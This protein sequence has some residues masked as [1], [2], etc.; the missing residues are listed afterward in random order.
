MNS[1][2]ILQH[3]TKRNE[4]FFQQKTIKTKLN[5]RAGIN[6]TISVFISKKNLDQ[7]ECGAMKIISCNDI[8]AMIFINDIFS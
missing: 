2:Q 3:K 1:E 7:S 5:A 6:K 8:F 4:Y